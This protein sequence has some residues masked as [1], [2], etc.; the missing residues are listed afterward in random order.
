LPVVNGSTDSGEIE[1][2][3]RGLKTPL[4]VPYID[5]AVTA[6]SLRVSRR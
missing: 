4:R 3:Y 5:S 2:D 6:K 1:G